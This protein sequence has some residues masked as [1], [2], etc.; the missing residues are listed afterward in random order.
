[1]TPNVFFHV[2]EGP[3][4][5]RDI[6]DAS[7]FANGAGLAVSMHTNGALFD[8]ERWGKLLGALQ[9]GRNLQ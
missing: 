1:M 6:F 7:H 3:L 5:H 9:K 2:M 8:E 4:L